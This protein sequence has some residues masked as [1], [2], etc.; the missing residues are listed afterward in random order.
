MHERKSSLLD[1]IGLGF[2]VAF[3]HFHIWLE[4][5]LLS[6]GTNR[7]TTTVLPGRKVGNLGKRRDGCLDLPFL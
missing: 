1:L 5:F 7:T 4:G 3:S 2:G 6:A